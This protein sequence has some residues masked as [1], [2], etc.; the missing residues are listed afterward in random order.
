MRTAGHSFSFGPTQPVRRLAAAATFCVELPANF[1]ELFITHLNTGAHVWVAAFEAERRGAICNQ[2]R[3]PYRP[4]ILPML[5]TTAN[6]GR[7]AR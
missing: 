7:E 4:V 2:K 3:Q 1:S 6:E 5:Q